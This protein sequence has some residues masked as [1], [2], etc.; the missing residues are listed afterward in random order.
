MNLGNN[1][2]NGAQNGLTVWKLW[3]FD[4]LKKIGKMPWNPVPTQNGTGSWKLKMPRPWFLNGEPVPSYTGTVSWVYFSGFCQ[5]FNVEPG[6]YPYRNRF[7]RTKKWFSAV[8]TAFIHFYSNPFLPIRIPSLE[9]P[10]YI[11]LHHLTHQTTYFHLLCSST[12]TLI[13][14]IHILTQLD[15]NWHH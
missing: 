6:S 9:T 11:L 2:Q 3:I 1:V 13:I 15:S 14:S 12:D 7:L 5:F 10:N 8:L 4:V